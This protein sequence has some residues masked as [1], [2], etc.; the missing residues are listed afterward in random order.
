MEREIMEGRYHSVELGQ[1]CSI[2][3]LHSGVLLED[4]G[5]IV[6]ASG[7][8]APVIISMLLYA[9]SLISLAPCAGISPSC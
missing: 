2:P 3:L 8:F 4:P 9:D 6:P 5:L 7:G 1:V